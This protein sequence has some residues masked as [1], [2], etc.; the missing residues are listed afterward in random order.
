MSTRT[1]TAILLATTS[2]CSEVPIRETPRAPAGALTAKAT[3]AAARLAHAWLR[4]RL[5]PTRLASSFESSGPEGDL[6]VT[7]D[8]A[9]AVDAFLV[10]GDVES[11]RRVLDGMRALQLPDGGWWTMYSCAH[12][13]VAESNQTVGQVVWMSLAVAKYEQFTG[14]ATTYHAMGKA[15]LDWAYRF[16]AP[17]GGVNGGIVA[18]AVAPWAGTEFNEDVYAASVYFGGHDEQARR[19][20]AFLDGAVWGG[21]HFMAGRGDPRDPLDVNAWSV[22]SLGRSG[23]HPYERTLDYNLGHHRVTLDGF[24]AFD[25]NSDR[26]D[27]W[28]EG[29]GE[30]ILSLKEVGRRAEADHFMQELVKAQRA[31]GGIPYSLRGTFNDYW[32]MSAAPC[33]SS[34]GWLILAEAEENPFHFR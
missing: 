3:S 29:T 11:A 28:F 12:G 9:V 21:D 27:I 15:A 34:T 19:V 8:Q 16:Q 18:G 5:R 25:F 7:Y 6:C 13:T 2:A 30:M 20:R 4:G 23:P 32:Q 14:D 26:N 22:P 10:M 33:I 31:N 17:D 24:D 1:F